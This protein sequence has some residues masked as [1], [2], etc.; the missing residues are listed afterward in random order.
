MGGKTE[1]RRQIF[2]FGVLVLACS[3]LASAASSGPVTY[4]VVIDTSSIGGAGGAVGSLDMNF[5]PGLFATQAASL[6]IVNLA[7]D[8]TLAASSSAIGD[9]SGALPGA[10]TFDNGTP[11][12]DSFQGF[13]FGTTILFS[14]T[15]FGPALSS[16]DGVSTS[17]ST[18]GFSMFSDAAGTQPVLTTDTTDGFAFVVDVNLDGT[19]TVTNF[20]NEA[21][22]TQCAA[23]TITALT[24]TPNVL[25]PPNHKELPVTVSAA[26]SGGCGVVSCR[27]LSV[28]S[29]EPLDA[30]GDFVLTGDLTLN[31]RAERL[32]NGTGRIYTIP[33]QCTD[34]FGNSA[35]QT[36]AVTV[37]HDQGH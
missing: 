6:R 28:S 26:T 17:G 8:G 21:T 11:F 14:F 1:M 4:S 37:P 32:G 33:V 34:S 29:N 23:P 30:D 35:T 18:F 13:T 15:L 19:T 2:M 9:V 22:V 10:L 20:S 3:G 25:F 31:L 24:A 36:T 12:N 5:N 16:P 7:G 27:I